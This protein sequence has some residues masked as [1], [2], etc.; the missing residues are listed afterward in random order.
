MKDISNKSYLRIRQAQYFLANA[1]IRN[2]PRSDFFPS[3]M[4]IADAWWIRKAI[5]G[6]SDQQKL[7]LML[8]DVSHE[9]KQTNAD[10]VRA[11]RVGGNMGKNYADDLWNA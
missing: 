5:L 9:H 11:Y 3:A 6:R 4:E 2:G 10:S 7:A 1:I 8:I